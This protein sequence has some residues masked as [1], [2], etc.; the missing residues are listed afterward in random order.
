MRR[1]GMTMN[2]EPPV[3]TDRDLRH[4]RAVASMAGI[5]DEQIWTDALAECVR[6]GQPWTLIAHALSLTKEELRKRFRPIPGIYVDPLS[7][8]E[9]HVRSADRIIIVLPGGGQMPYDDAPDDFVLL[10]ARER[11]EL[12]PNLPRR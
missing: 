7:R 4:L 1:T 5:T 9:W 10:A 12:R 6:N 11:L 3:D 2:T 8:N